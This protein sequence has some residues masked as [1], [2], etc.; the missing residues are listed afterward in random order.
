[1]KTPTKVM[2]GFLFAFGASAV[3]KLSKSEK[4]QENLKKKLGQAQEQLQDMMEKASQ[5]V[6]PYVDQAKASISSSKEA[7]ADSVA[8]MDDEED[9]DIEIE[10]KDLDLNK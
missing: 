5:K 3:Y 6:A 4:D 8:Q 9:E 7:L 2:A 10:E 1:M